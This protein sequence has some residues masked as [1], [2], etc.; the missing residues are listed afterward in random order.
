MA[1]CVS[2]NRFKYHGAQVSGNPVVGSRLARPDLQPLHM[3]PLPYWP[4]WSDALIHAIHRRVLEHIR[5]VAG[6]RTA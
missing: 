3:R 2:G 6:E 4:L 5:D 1:P